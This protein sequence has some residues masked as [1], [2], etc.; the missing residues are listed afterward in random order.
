MPDI[1]QVTAVPLAEKV[2]T[3]EK[4]GISRRTHEEHF[5]LYQ[6]YANKTNEL[7]RLMAELDRD[8]AKANQVYSST[9]ALKV[10]YTFAY[11]GYLNHT[12]FFDILGGDGQCKGLAKEM[13]EKE[14]GSVE[15]WAAD[16]KSSG[17]AGRGWVWLAVDHNDGSL[18]NFI[19][20]AQNTYPVWNCTPVLALDVYEH[21][22]Y[23]DFGT[24]RAAYIDAFLKVVD[25]EAVNRHLAAA[26]S[27]VLGHPK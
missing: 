7:R 11:G 6:G 14:F 25:W 1:K 13:I 8:P 9:R 20:D 2:F 23:L 27:G 21:A 17:I 15:A 19:G 5:K 18:F 10:D 4:V 3:T 26:T 22:Y 24:G 16:L 12:L